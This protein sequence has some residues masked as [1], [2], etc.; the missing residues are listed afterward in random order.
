MRV[1]WSDEERADEWRLEWLSSRPRSNDDELRQLSRLTCRQ[2]KR[3]LL[4]GAPFVT[5][6][7]P[8]N[9]LDELADNFFCHLHNHDH[10]HEHEHEH[11][12]DAAPHGSKDAAG[13]DLTNVLNPLRDKRVLR[14][15]VLRNATVFVT[16]RNHL[17]SPHLLLEEEH[18]ETEKR[19]HLTRLRCA[20]CSFVI[21]YKGARRKPK[22]TKILSAIKCLRK[23]KCLFFF[24]CDF[25][26]SK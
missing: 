24:V 21:G 14:R 22:R 17:E 18:N 4:K 15:A 5:L 20:S 23:S 12:H 6:A 25:S 7:L 19:R 13:E 2:C 10:E 9:E 8:D 16:N 26:T 11:S 1:K 3:D